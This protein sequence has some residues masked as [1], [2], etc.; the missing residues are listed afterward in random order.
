[1]QMRGFLLGFIV[2]SILVIILHGCATTG[3]NY[4][5]PMPPLPGP[6]INDW[7]AHA[8]DGGGQ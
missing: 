7:Q 1:M 8:P 3:P 6:N 2:G 5:P 4:L